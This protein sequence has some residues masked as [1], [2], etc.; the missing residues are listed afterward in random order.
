MNQITVVSVDKIKDGIGK[1]KNPW[2]L[3]K[4]TFR[5]PVKIFEQ[6]G[7]EHSFISGSTFDELAGN[8]KAS[9][10]LEAE[11]EISED[12]KY[13]NLKKINLTGGPT[14]RPSTTPEP[15]KPTQPPQKPQQQPI[16]NKDEQIAEAVAFKGVIDLLC[17]KVINLEHPLAQRANLFM[18]EHLPGLKAE[19]RTLIESKL[20]EMGA[21]KVAEGEEHIQPLKLPVFKTADQLW[22]YALAHGETSLTF[23][24]KTGCAMPADIT[25]LKAAVKAIY[26]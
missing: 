8:L 9:D 1:N 21:E 19:T 6:D 5:E 17:A 15:V 4:I 14:R 22:K 12:G 20:K 18:N 25:D 24:E 7:T 26:P 11:C 2:T 13:L 16:S 3:R 10:T 23:K